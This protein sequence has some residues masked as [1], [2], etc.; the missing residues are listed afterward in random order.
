MCNL[1][2]VVDLRAFSYAGLAEC[3]AVDGCVCAYL[4]VILKDDIYANLR[5]Q[6]APLRRQARSQAIAR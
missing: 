3:G 4:Y 5:D 1:D 6:C 2:Q